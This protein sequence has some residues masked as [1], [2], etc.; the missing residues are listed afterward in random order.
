MWYDKRTVFIIPTL[1]CTCK[2][3][4]RLVLLLVHIRIKQVQPVLYGVSKVW[5]VLWGVVFLVWYCRIAVFIILTF[6]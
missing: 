1:T 4:S 3:R 6:S 5:W 2:I